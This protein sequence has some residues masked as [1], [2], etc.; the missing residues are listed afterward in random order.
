[1]LLFFPVPCTPMP[2]LPQE[3]SVQ[4]PLNICLLINC[5][6]CARAYT[7]LH[8]SHFGIAMRKR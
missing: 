6:T 4:E 8:F 7:L 3:A 5:M 2:V 1:M